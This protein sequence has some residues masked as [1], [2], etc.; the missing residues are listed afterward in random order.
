MTGEEAF[1]FWLKEKGHDVLFLKE[2]DGYELSCGITN[3]RLKLRVPFCL[4]IGPDGMED[5][6]QVEEFSFII[7]QDMRHDQEE[8]YLEN[9]QVFTKEGFVNTDEETVSLAIG[10]QEMQVEE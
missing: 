7:V 8:V 2:N 1:E 4:P 10:W 9:I 6:E 5:G 3:Y